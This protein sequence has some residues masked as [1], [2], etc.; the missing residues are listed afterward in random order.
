M[1][2]WVALVG[3]ETR[4][5]QGAE[6]K[7]KGTCTVERGMLR[8]LRTWSRFEER[9]GEIC[10]EGWS[11][12]TWKQWEGRI[13]VIFEMLRAR[14]SFERADYFFHRVVALRLKRKGKEKD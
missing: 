1:I 2:T 9:R 12:K 13:F 4:Q 11:R 8:I 14:E 7:K 6:K 3:M 5:G 10:Q